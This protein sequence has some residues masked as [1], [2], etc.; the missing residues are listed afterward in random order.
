VLA[1][2]ESQARGLTLDGIRS[3]ERYEEFI[4]LVEDRVSAGAL[5]RA[6]DGIPTRDELLA[7]PERKRGLPRPLLC[8]LLGHTKMWAFQ[9]VMETDFPDSETGK[10]FLNLYF[11]Q[12]L[13][14]FA[15]HFETHALRREIIATA[16]VNYVINN[17]GVASLQ[18]LM[19]ATKAEIG[20]VMAAY[21]EADGQC[22][23]RERRAAALAAGQPASDEHAAML[24]IEE[25]IET[26]ARGAVGAPTS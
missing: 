7:S 19:S 25:T 9:K 23:A 14:G 8:L 12:R 21:L 1:D 4:Q 16:A 11:P 6:D 26:A 10:P 24:A 3:A 20:D 13:Q 18:R 5:N 22:K 15:E 2:N 17:A